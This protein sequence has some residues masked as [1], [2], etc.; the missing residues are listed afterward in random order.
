MIATGI[1][2]PHTIIRMSCKEYDKPIFRSN[3]VSPYPLISNS[4]NNKLRQT[5]DYKALKHT[6]MGTESIDAGHFILHNLQCHIPYIWSEGWFN[7][8]MSSYR[9]RKTIVEIK[10]SYDCLIST[11]V[12]SIQIIQHLYDES[13]PWNLFYYIYNLLNKSPII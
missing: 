3:I 13:G 12:F 6:K 8:K 9:Y 11:M 7:I 10:W 1:R 5:V 2:M 4:S